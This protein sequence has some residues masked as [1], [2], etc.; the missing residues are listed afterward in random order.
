MKSLMDFTEYKEDI[1]MDWMDF[2]HD[3]EVDDTEFMLG[4][5]MLC[6]RR[7]SCL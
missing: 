7:E 3:G 2:N 5:E 4:E 1:T 6:S